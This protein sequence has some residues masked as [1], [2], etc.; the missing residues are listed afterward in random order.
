MGFNG[1]INSNFCEK[2]EK[3][4]HPFLQISLESL[5]LQVDSQGLDHLYHLLSWDK[6]EI[7]RESLAQNR[8]LQQ[9]NKTGTLKQ[10]LKIVSCWFALYLCCHWVPL[11]PVI[12]LVLE[13]QFL[14]FLLVTLK[15]QQLKVNS[16]S[17]EL[18]CHIFPQQCHSVLPG[19]PLSPGGPC[20]P[21]S[22]AGPTG[23][24]SGGQHSQKLKKHSL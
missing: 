17:F 22:P 13:I 6:T 14:P 21:L 16:T 18:P 15:K 2:N 20:G 23:P 11:L 3:L 5:G 7:C 24:F 1:E 8:I 19:R 12:Q 10:T 9:K 4:A